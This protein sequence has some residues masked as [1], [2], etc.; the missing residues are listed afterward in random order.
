MRTECSPSG[1]VFSWI[2]S[3]I[4][5]AGEYSPEIASP[6]P[7]GGKTETEF[8]PWKRTNKA[9]KMKDSYEID[10]VTL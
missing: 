6:I 2:R 4:D 3:L 7:N 10:G 8:R 1:T 9:G 5:A